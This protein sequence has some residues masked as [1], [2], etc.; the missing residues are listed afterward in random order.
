MTDY[1]RRKIVTTRIEYGVESGSDIGTFLK[2]MGFAWSEYCEITGA[3]HTRQ[4]EDWA[5]V[6][7]HDDEIVIAFAV[8]KEM[9]ET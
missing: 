8:D 6:T 4:Y 1:A 2:I 5:I 9:R 3:N 7:P